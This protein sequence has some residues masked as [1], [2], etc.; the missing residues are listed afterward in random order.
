MAIGETT[1]S[2][3][4]IPF[5]Y[6]I[7][8]LI[9]ILYTGEISNINE[10]YPV[11]ML[12]GITGAFL[13]TVHPVQRSIDFLMKRNIKNDVYDK[14]TIKYN[15][16]T[17]PPEKTIEISKIYLKLSL[18]TSSIKHELNK[19]ASIFYFVIILIGIFYALT[20]PSFQEILGIEIFGVHYY[21]FETIVVLMISIVSLVLALEAM[22]FN[23]RIR[24]VALFF[25][26]TNKNI[27]DVPTTIKTAI[28]L[29]DWHSAKELLDHF[30]RR[31]WNNI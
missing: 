22:K 14:Y 28:D 18:N 13:V 8:N 17:V 23:V 31:H 24:I 21:I 10:F 11:L 4:D 15:P 3:S 6:S 9:F 1:L 25:E 12:S 20:Q 7:I 26:F 16:S 29:N 19:Q 5:S 2:L 30:L 27:G